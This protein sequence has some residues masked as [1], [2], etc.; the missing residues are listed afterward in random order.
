[1]LSWLR[2]LVSKP[3]PPLKGSPKVR[4]EKTYSAETGYVYQYFYLGYREAE[5]G[6]EE[7]NEHLFSVTSDRTSRFTLKLFLGRN[8]LAPWETENKRELIPTEQYALVKLSL[9]Q[10]FDERTDFDG[11][12]AE[13]AITPEQ[14]HEHVNTLDL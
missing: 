9:F 3:P 12:N 14:V 7:G 4:R 6:G 13:V 5:R 8:A 10:T 2:N 1:M 11:E